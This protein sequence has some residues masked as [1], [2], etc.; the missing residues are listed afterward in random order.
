MGMVNIFLKYIVTRLAHAL[1]AFQ[2]FMWELY[3]PTPLMYVLLLLSI[4]H[5]LIRNILLKYSTFLFNAHYVVSQ[6]ALCL[7]KELINMSH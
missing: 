6:E 4:T 3:T 1:L 7:R 5:V 2:L